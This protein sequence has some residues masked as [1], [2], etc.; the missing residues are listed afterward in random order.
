MQ[1]QGKIII[2][3]DHPLFRAALH[4]ALYQSLGNLQFLEGENF[5]AMQALAA[6]HPD[7]ELVLLDLNMPGAHGLSGLAFL[8]GHYPALPVVVVSAYEEPALVYRALD[9]GASGFI[10]KSTP[11]PLLQTALKAIMAGDIWLPPG[12]PPR[13]PTE[14]PAMQDLSARLGSLTPQQ[15]RV[16]L[17]MVDGLLNKQIAAQMEVS[18]AT[19]KAHITAILRKLG[20]QSRTQAVALTRSL[21]LELPPQP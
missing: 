1:S 3:D 19:V 7:A 13:P 9:L 4:Q 5:E 14:L 10:P 15:Y 11:L 17:L 6:A 21:A 8:R 16:F 20:A 12:L 18:E 2:A